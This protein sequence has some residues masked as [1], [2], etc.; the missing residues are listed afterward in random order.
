MCNQEL[1]NFLGQLDLLCIEGYDFERPLDGGG[2]SASAIYRKADEQV[3]FKFLIA[4]RNDI[5]LE[6]FKLEHSF[7][8]KS[9]LNCLGQGK[10]YFSGPENS[11]PVPTIKLPLQIIKGGFISYFAYDFEEGELLS[12][13]DF[14]MLCFDKKLLLLHRIA[15]GL[16]YFSRSYYDHRDLH[17][18]NILLRQGYDM[19]SNPEQPDPRVMILDLGNCQVQPATRTYIREDCNEDAVIQDNNRRLLTSFIS[20]PPD[21]L[22]EGKN[23]KNYDT[24]AFGVFAYEVFFDELPFEIN[25]ISDVTKL[26]NKNSFPIS[27]TQNLNSL[28][29]SL[30]LIFER[31]LSPSGHERPALWAMVKLIYWVRIEEP[32]GS[33][34]TRYINELIDNNGNDPAYDL[35]YEE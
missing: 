20:M 7:L 4:P 17:P 18:E 3:V 10:Q 25:D 9:Y 30:K 23:I 32:K 13:L 11:Y 12:T 26:R 35:R 14:R 22:I 21:F 16:S 8:T 2:S 31:A 29:P 5:E 19:D 24:W 6:R 15:S 27:F 1:R 34:S 33:Y 28:K